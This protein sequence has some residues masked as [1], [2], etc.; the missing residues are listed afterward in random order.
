MTRK[1][2]G[3][4]YRELKASHYGSQKSTFDAENYF[5]R[6]YRPISF[7]PSA[8]LIRWG[9]SANSVTAW[10]AV[11]SLTAFAMLSMGKFQAG[12]YLYLLAYLIDFV[13]GN[14]ARYTGK[15]TYFG[16]MIDGLVDTLSFLLFVALGFGNA[17]YGNAWFGSKVEVV[18]GLA[19][20]FIFLFRSYFYLRV[21]Y[22]MNQPRAQGLVDPQ[23]KPVVDG[24]SAVISGRSW[25]ISYGKKIY[26]GLISGMPVFLLLAATLNAVSLY[27]GVYFFVFILA[28]SFEVAYGLRRVWLKDRSLGV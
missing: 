17:G 1:S 12:S 11:C 18:L 2:A 10:G 13:D 24:G 20:A 21:S 23:T 27:L 9:V 14:I 8:I 5:Y 6:W 3:V 16:K 26:F 19:T 4:I 28:T 22:I 25:M 7:F 15:A